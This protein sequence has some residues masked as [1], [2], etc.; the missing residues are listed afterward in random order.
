MP[1]S[2]IKTIKDLIFWEFAKLI[3]GAALSDSKN[4]GFVIYNFKQLQSGQKDG[5]IY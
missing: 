1:P 2:A 3:S 5:Q 4:Y